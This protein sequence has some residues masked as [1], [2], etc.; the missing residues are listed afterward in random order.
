MIKLNNLVGPGTAG[1][2]QRISSSE[3]KYSSDKEVKYLEGLDSEGL[4]VLKY[5]KLLPC[6][7]NQY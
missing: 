3:E 2:A 1:V 4:E 6:G 5:H 7:H